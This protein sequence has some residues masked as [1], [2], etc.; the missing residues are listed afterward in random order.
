M[1][2]VFSHTCMLLCHINV[3]SYLSLRPGDFL[4]SLSGSMKYIF[5]QQLLTLFKE[6]LKHLFFLYH[7]IQNSHP[8]LQHAH[9]Y[10]LFHSS[11]HIEEIVLNNQSWWTTVLE[12]MT[13]W[14]LYMNSPI[15]ESN[16]G[17]FLMY[18]SLTTRSAYGGSGL[19]LPSWQ[20]PSWLY[21]LYCTF[22]SEISFLYTPKAY[23]PELKFFYIMTI[24][25]D[26][27]LSY[28]CSSYLIVF[29]FPHKNL[30][31][32]KIRILLGFLCWQ[33]KEQCC[34]Y[35]W[36]SVHIHWKLHW[37]VFLPVIMQGRCF[38]SIPVSQMMKL[39]FKKLTQ[40][41]MGTVNEKKKSISSK[42]HVS[43]KSMFFTKFKSQKWDLRHKAK[44]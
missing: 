24:S 28:L 15:Y 25:L 2:A 14:N 18:S 9:L 36:H 40:L 43:H 37:D 5:L 23:I 22:L 7:S 16:V 17:W 33:G 11:G 21:V 6:L 38:C 26:I 10:H 39:K 41:P 27:L 42:L 19:L 29:C 20:K 1:A 44:Q 13:D 35:H 8:F 3:R 30:N 32:G 12:Q 4:I 34:K 31:V